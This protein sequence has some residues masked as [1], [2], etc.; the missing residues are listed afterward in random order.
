MAESVTAVRESRP[1]FELFEGYALASVLAALEMSELLSQ[2]E[3]GGLSPAA[4]ADRDD[5]EAA[6]L[7]A[8]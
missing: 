6:L 3:G 1:A 5:D 8:S 2:L 4:I 7:A